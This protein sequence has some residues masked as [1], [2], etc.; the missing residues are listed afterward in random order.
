MSSVVLQLKEGDLKAILVYAEIDRQLNYIQPEQP[1]PRAPA[2]KYERFVSTDNYPSTS[3]EYR[4]EYYRL[5][6]A[7]HPERI[8]QY[9]RN[10]RARRRGG[11]GSHTLKELKLLFDK[12]EGRC[13]YC[14]S[15]LYSSFDNE[16]HV[17]HKTP[18]IRGGSNYIE[19]IA[20]ACA[21]CNRRKHTKTEEEFFRTDT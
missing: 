8:K 5:Y 20:I 18:L 2:R 10:R 11:V 15:L 4:R 14:S 3:L 19:N 17:D 6:R 1:K 16:I 7:E 21:P 12:Q 13:H 9:L